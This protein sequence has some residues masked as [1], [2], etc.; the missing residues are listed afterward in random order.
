MVDTDELRRS[1]AEIAALQRGQIEI[2]S[3]VSDTNDHLHSMEEFLKEIK[4]MLADSKKKKKI[5]KEEDS[6]SDVENNNK[7]QHHH[8]N[9]FH[10]GNRGMHVE[11]PIFD[12]ERVEE[13]VFKN[14]FYDPKAA[15]KEL[16]QTDSVAEYH[17]Q[18][19]ELST[20]VT[21]LSEDWLVSLFIVGLQEYLKYELMIAKPQEYDTAVALAKL[22]EQKHAA[23][24]THSIKSLKPYTNPNSRNTITYFST[25]TPPPNRIP[26]TKHTHNLTTTLA[27]PSPTTPQTQP[28]HI[29]NTPYK[30]LSAEEVKLKRSKGLCYYCEDKWS[31][32]HCCKTTLHLLIGEDAMQELLRE[33]PAEEVITEG[34]EQPV[35]IE[36]VQLEI[37]FNA[38]VGQYQPTTFRLKGTYNGQPLM[39][40]IDGGNTHNFVK[41]SVAQ[42]LAIPM[43]DVTPLQL[44]VRNG[45]SIGCQA[46]CEKIA[47]ILQGYKFNISTYVLDL[48]GADLVL[49]VQWLMGL[50]YVTT[51][52]GLL[53]MEFVVHDLKVKLQ[54]ERLLQS[55]GLSS[56]MLQKLVTNEVITT[57]YHL[58]MIEG[59]TNSKPTASVDIQ[60]LLEEFQQVFE[61]P[62]RLPPTREIDHKIELIL[63]AQPI[64]VRPYKYLQFQKE[65]MERLIAEML[66][67]G[68]IRESHSAFSSPVILV[69]KK[70]G[71]WRFCIDYKALNAITVKDKFSIPN[72]EEI[73]DELFG[74][75]YFSKIDLRSGYHQIIMNENSVHMTAFRTHLGHYEFV[76]HMGGSFGASQ[77]YSCCPTLIIWD[78]LYALW[79]SK[80]TILKLRQYKL[81]RKPTSLKQLRGFLGLTGYY[82][83]FVLGYAQLAHP[84]TE[85]LKKNNFHWGAEA[86]MAFDKLKTTMTHTPVLS[87]LDFSQ[88]FT[89]ETDASN[90][91][92]GAVLSHNG[93]PLAYFSKKLNPKLAM[94]SAY[95]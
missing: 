66:E 81:G 16:K 78:M 59:E 93:H 33:P 21:G 40:L 15:L 29:P 85:L 91:G 37:S 45:D 65:E 52:Y 26:T 35:I 61:E 8:S 5:I 86:D 77:N 79:E 9:H 30:H 28:K 90:T 87:L 48:Q 55:E 88:R 10:S 70:D 64:K 42:R 23:N 14:Y 67:T 71:G 62:T 56:R 73:L 51:H 54:G 3:K 20:Q 19:E 74:A 25:P 53:T 49:G 17:T 58:R 50:G 92:I 24:L 22:H 46:Q 4:G 18:F 12:G 82:R 32:S 41:T 75:E 44:L 94:S 1:Q 63:G 72:I 34:P 36:L 13:W 68:V 57:F 7:Q 95:I 89:V 27:A 60:Q 11:L 31:P 69:R 47:L 39:M 43:R 80:L 84:L 83:K 6:D 38:M 76:P 2:N